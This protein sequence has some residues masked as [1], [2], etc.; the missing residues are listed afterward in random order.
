MRP[1]SCVLRP[2][3]CARAD[4]LQFGNVCETHIY[5]KRDNLSLARSLRA[6]SYLFNRVRIFILMLIRLEPLMERELH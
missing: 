3:E 2:R 4:V 5:D 6:L 1:L